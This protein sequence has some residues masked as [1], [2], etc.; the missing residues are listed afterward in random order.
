MQIACLTGPL[1]NFLVQKH[2]KRSIW[3]AIC[4][5]EFR[6]PPTRLLLCLCGPTRFNWVL[7]S[8]SYSKIAETRMGPTCK[9][10]I[11][12]LGPKGWIEDFLL[13]RVRKFGGLRDIDMHSRGLRLRSGWIFVRL[14][15]SGPSTSVVVG[16]VI[17]EIVWTSKKVLLDV[18]LVFNCSCGG[19]DVSLP[20]ESCFR[21]LALPSI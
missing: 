11:R 16:R 4:S 5:Y 9:R 15:P 3:Y 19:V 6:W 21:V 12:G 10:L 7:D 18:H 17:R 20:F 8:A 13:G 1:R 14:Q 2:T